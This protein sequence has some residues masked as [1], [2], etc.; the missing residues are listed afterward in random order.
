MISLGLSP[1]HRCARGSPTSSRCRRATVWF[2]FPSQR[3]PSAGLGTV[4]PRN[5]ETAHKE[6]GNPLLLLPSGTSLPN[7]GDRTRAGG[8]ATAALARPWVGSAPIPSPPGHS[9]SMSPLP[10]EC[11]K[12]LPCIFIAGK[13]GKRSALFYFIA[14]PPRAGQGSTAVC[15][16]EY[17]ITKHNASAPSAA[18]WDRLLRGPCMFISFPPPNLYCAINL[19]S[20]SL[21]FL[22]LKPNLPLSYLLPLRRT[23]SLACLQ[24]PVPTWRGR[25]GWPEQAMPCVG[26]SRMP[27]VC[28]EPA[29]LINLFP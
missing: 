17:L 10:A 24:P 7:A 28:W 6:A 29:S 14:P 13:Q 21:H 11:C 20:F 9:G 16:S 23:P 15:A 12:I 27:S 19:E 25:G 18:C 1:G 5:H 22:F 3:P 4:Q 8:K 26:V 2:C